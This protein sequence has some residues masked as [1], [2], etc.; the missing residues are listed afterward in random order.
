M[1]LPLNEHPLDWYA[2]PELK[3]ESVEIMVPLASGGGFFCRLCGGSPIAPPDI[4]DHYHT[5][6]HIENSSCLEARRRQ[7]HELLQQTEDE[8]RKR[9]SK[10][11]KQRQQKA[12]LQD[13]SARLERLEL[14]NA[15]LQQ[16]RLE[17]A[18]REEEARRR[19]HQ[20]TRKQAELAEREAARRER[21]KLLEQE[22]L[23]ARREQERRKLE[24]QKLAEREASQRHAQ[25]RREEQDRRM[26]QLMAE[27]EA[28]KRN[29]KFP[30]ATTRAT[31]TDLRDLMEQRKRQARRQASNSHYVLP[32]RESVR[33]PVAVQY[34]CSGNKDIEVTLLK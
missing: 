21:L 32:T 28:R 3:G 15:R 34:L 24:Q 33:G 20:E 7:V 22:K 25:A 29:M 17:D 6:E 4:L 5:P 16:E 11:A 9:R 14:E 26:K 10:S 2:V 30:S 23:A 31:T 1:V 18:E 12:Q 19:E 13:M 8:L 27:K